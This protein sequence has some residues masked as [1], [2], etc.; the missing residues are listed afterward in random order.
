MYVEFLNNENA[1]EANLVVEPK[2]WKV[3]EVEAVKKFLEYRAQSIVK[4]K[5]GQSISVHEELSLNCIIL[6]DGMNSL[7]SSDLEYGFESATW[8]SMVKE[9]QDRYEIDDLPAETELA[10][11]T[12][13]KAARQD[14]SRVDSS[15]KKLPDGD[16]KGLIEESLRSLVSRYAP[17]TSNKVTKLESSFTMEVV[18]PVLLPFLKENGMLSRKGTD[19]KVPDAANNNK[20]DIQFSDLSVFFKYGEDLPQEGLVMVE[21]KPPIKVN[22]GHRPDYV[23]LGNELKSCIDKMVKDGLDD[24]DIVVTGVLIEGFMCTVFVM[25]LVYQA[26]YRMIPIAVFHL[27]RSRHDFIVLPQAYESL[28]KVRNLMLSSAQKCFAFYRKKE[29]KTI[30]DQ[31]VVESITTPILQTSSKIVA[32]GLP[33]QASLLNTLPIYHNG[34]LRRNIESIGTERENFMAEELKEAKQDEKG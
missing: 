13:T 30:R 5:A 21:I 2:K 15:I 11:T 4:A 14:F 25:D 9:C 7:D 19:G 3:G 24:E 6:V 22:N 16:D 10:I 28:L 20:K 31:Y 12:I 23:K 26:T 1:P 27:P 29:R 32:P 17:N 33:V 8:E 18:D 34:M